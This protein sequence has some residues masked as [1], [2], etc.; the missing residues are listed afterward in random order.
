MQQP[1][2]SD[3]RRRGTFKHAV[4]LVAAAFASSAR[5]DAP[6]LRARIQRAADRTLQWMDDRR[7]RRDQEAFGD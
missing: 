2:R 6:W 3:Q 5:P 1:S 4:A 7:D